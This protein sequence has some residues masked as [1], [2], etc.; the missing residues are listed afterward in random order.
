[1][2]SRWTRALIGA[3]LA[4]GLAV[5]LC[6]TA[7]CAGSPERGQEGGE[8]V[9]EQQQSVTGRQAEAPDG[10]TLPVLSRVVLDS[11][12]VVE[13]LRQGDGAE[14]P[15]DAVVEVRYHATLPDGRVIDTTRNGEPVQ[16]PLDSLIEGWREGVPGMR[17][18]G[19]RLL[20][21]PAALAYG[22]EG[23]GP[24]PPGSPMVFS[25]ELVSVVG[26]D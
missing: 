16:L 23:Q 4:T 12:V 6:I 8:R 5:P 19:I 10:A 26:E 13:E 24:V 17:E 14:C 25:I 11:G 20:R 7:G 9:D 22:A 21:I 2:P 1:M 3:G 18:G 15:P